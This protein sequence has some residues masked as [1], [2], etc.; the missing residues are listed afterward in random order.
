M[1]RIAA[2]HG[3]NNTYSGPRSMASEWIPALLDGVDLSGSSSLLSSD[4]IACV[5][6]GDLF[7]R[8]AGCSAMKTWLS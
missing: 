7:R 2:V 8:P 1:A 5:F 6:Y 4:D 3:I